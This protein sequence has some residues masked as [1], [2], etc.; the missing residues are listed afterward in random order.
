MPAPR[1][2]ALATGNVARA[3]PELAGDRGFIE[4]GKRADIVICDAHNLARVRH[5]IANGRLVVEN[6][7]IL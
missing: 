5:V 2:V 4:R 1:A 6:A 7:R 3:I